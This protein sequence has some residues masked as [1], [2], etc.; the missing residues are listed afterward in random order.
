[1]AEEQAGVAAHRQCSFIQL[2]EAGLLALH[3]SVVHKKRRVSVG[4]RWVWEQPTYVKLKKVIL[5]NKKRLTVKVGTQVVDR[6]EIQSEPTHLES[7]Q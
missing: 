2:Q 4:G 3:A 5:P 6:M 7:E 1:M